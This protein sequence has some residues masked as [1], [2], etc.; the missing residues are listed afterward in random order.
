MK[1]ASA[2][3]V[4]KANAHE[5]YAA[6]QRRAAAQAPAPPLRLSAAGFD[7]IAEIKLRSPAAG[8]LGEASDNWMGRA[9]AYASAGAAAVSVL[10]EESRFDGS[11]EHL[12]A[13]A[14]LLVEEEAGID[15]RLPL[16]V[17]CGQRGR[18]RGMQVRKIGLYAGE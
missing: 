5:N 7:V 14:G 12:R 16:R 6:L 3:R 2:L 10:T 13:A 1:S 15:G 17:A 9:C 8:V 11:L 18:E 4:A